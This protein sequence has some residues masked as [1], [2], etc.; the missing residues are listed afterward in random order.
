M[1]E[2][3]LVTNVPTPTRSDAAACEKLSKLLP[4]TIGDGLRTRTVHPDSPFLHAWGTPAAVLR[5]GVGYPPHYDAAALPGTIDG[6]GWYSTEASDS[7]IF[8]TLDRLP[9]VSVAIPHKYQISFDL[10][11]DLSDALKKATTGS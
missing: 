8:T 6:I 10:L 2:P 5:C 7:V 9:R 3:V 1:T 4:A 11:V